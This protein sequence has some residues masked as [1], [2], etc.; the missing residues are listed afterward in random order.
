MPPETPD[1]G[2]RS[3]F[4]KS[5]NSVPRAAHA[6]RNGETSW[7]L[8]DANEIRRLT[9]LDF[10]NKREIA[11]LDPL[12]GDLFTTTSRVMLAGPTGLGKTNLMMAAGFAMADGADFL[13]WRGCGGQRRVLYIDGEMPRRLLKARIDDAARRHGSRPPSFFAFNREDF[14]DMPPL[15]TAPGQQYV[16]SVIEALG[17]VDMLMLDNLQAL[18]VGEMREPESWRRIL[19]WVRQLTSRRMGQV[20]GH[21]TGLNEAHP[22]GDKSKEWQLDTV[23]LLEAVERPWADIAFK[24]KFTKARERTPDNRADFEPQI[25]TLERDQWFSAPVEPPKRQSAAPRAK[26]PSPVGV[27]FHDALTDALAHIGERRPEA[28]GLPSVTMA[29]W[30]AELDRLGLLPDGDDAKKKRSALVSKYRIELAAANWIA[31]N[32]GFIWSIRL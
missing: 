11:P 32:A 2:R 3:A 30:Q 15:D 29:Q 31:I 28:A 4:A 5:T 18:T 10:W 19:P 26:P 27:K 25:I 13:H 24:M 6:A 14:E 20:W 7:T 17:G 9:S 16:D 21:H 12:L 23:V 8:P 22:Y 1:Q